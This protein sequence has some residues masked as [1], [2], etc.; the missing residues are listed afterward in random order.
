M[1]HLPAILTLTTLH[2]CLF[3]FSLVLLTLFWN[4]YSFCLIAAEVEKFVLLRSTSSKV[5]DQ[6]IIITMDLT[7]KLA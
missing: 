4:Y 2:Y 1:T 3:A 6:C 7:L 5:A